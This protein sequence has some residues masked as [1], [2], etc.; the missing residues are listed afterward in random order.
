MRWRSNFVSIFFFCLFLDKL[1]W[2]SKRAKL[3]SPSLFG[4][5]MISWTS[6]E[7]SRSIILNPSICVLSS[8]IL[9]WFVFWERKFAVSCFIPLVW[10][11][12]IYS[13]SAKWHCFSLTTSSPF[14]V[15]WMNAD[16]EER[17]SVGSCCLFSRG[18]VTLTLKEAEPL[19][20]LVCS[21][22]DVAVNHSHSWF[23]SWWN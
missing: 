15:S 18:A 23:G 7:W 19:W 22:V 6:F 16:V 3:L 17:M 11:V 21:F 13:I 4:V 1:K 2:L 5:W 12:V 8:D 10:F 9:L 14:F 20:K